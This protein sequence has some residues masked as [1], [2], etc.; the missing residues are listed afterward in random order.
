MLLLNHDD[1]CIFSPQSE[2]ILADSPILP[3][4]EIVACGTC[5]PS[6]LPTLSDS[7]FDR[8]YGEAEFRIMKARYPPERV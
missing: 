7:G 4:S 6:F 1:I 8:R 3:I 5:V 2:T